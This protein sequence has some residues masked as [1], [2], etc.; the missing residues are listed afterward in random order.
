M[1]TR[2]KHAAMEALTRQKKDDLRKDFQKVLRKHGIEGWHLAEF[3]MAP[4]EVQLERAIS[5]PDDMVYDCRYVNGR[6]ICGC[7]PND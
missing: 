1:P 5:C 6:I 4:G 2:P 7:F 3:H